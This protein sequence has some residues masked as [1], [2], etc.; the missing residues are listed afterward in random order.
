VNRAANAYAATERTTESG[1]ITDAI[2]LEKAAF[3]LE[4]LK[5]DL[6]SEDWEDV[7]KYNQLIWTV[8]QAEMME[9]KPSPML[10]PQIRANLMSLSIYVDKRTLELLYNRERYPQDI[11]SLININRNIALGLRGNP[12]TGVPLEE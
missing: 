7:I 2:V 8:I 5:G 12:G 9:N 6:E 1:L 11:Q 3:M 4:D 10:T